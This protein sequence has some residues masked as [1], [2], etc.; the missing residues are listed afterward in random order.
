MFCLNYLLNARYKIDFGAKV[1]NLES[2]EKEKQQ[3][4]D[5]SHFQKQD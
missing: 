5:E 2:H 1:A 4:K 3:K